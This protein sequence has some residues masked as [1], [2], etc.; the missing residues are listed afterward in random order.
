MKL[1]T[2][3]TILA[4]IAIFYGLALLIMPGKFLENYGVIANDATVIMSRFFGSA[5]CCNAILFWLHRNVSAEEKSWSALLISSIFFNVI[6]FIIA[7]MAVTSSMVNSMGWS[8]VV[9]SALFALAS[10]YY[11][12]K[13]SPVKQK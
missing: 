11:A 4:I 3:A 12:F 8:T 10:A 1:S 7:L 13:K 9:L 2:Y 5:M 6:N